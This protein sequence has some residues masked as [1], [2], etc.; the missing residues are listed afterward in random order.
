MKLKKGWLR[1]KHGILLKRGKK[2][3]AHCSEC[4]KLFLHDIKDS[5]IQLAVNRLPLPDY[6]QS[7]PDRGVY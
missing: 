3:I 1:C 7:N 5:E 6:N 4:D 2:V